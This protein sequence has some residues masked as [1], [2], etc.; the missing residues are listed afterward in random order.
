M[1]NASLSSLLI[2]GPVTV[3][4]ALAGLFCSAPAADAAESTLDGFDAADIQAVGIPRMVITDAEAGGKSAADTTFA[5]GVMHVS[6][7]LA[8]GRGMPGFV[9]IPL[10]VAPDGSPTDMSE[11]TGVKLR[12]K[13]KSGA[14][15]VQVGTAVITNF[16]YHTSA[17]LTRDPD[18]FQEVKIPF[19]AMKQVWSAPTDLDLTTVTSINLVTAGMMPADFAYEIDEI[20]FY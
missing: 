8:P 16:D 10:V 5:D 13:V 4:M 14:L 7:K 15:S 11:Y 1:K 2:T 9:S 18:N 6:G 17:P 19:A 20:G 3:A 12:V